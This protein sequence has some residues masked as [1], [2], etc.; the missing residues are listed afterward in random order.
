MNANGTWIMFTIQE[1]L[2]ALPS[3]Q[4]K[5]VLHN[6]SVDKI[7]LVPD[8]ICGVILW[9][10]QTYVALDPSIMMGDAAQ[11]SSVYLLLSHKSQVCIKITRVIA[12][13]SLSENEIRWGCS[14]PGEDFRIGFF[15]MDE[16]QGSIIDE[17]ALVA[18]G[19][20]ILSY[21]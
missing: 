7:P 5:E 13:H 12:I 20:R 18:L 8:S 3:T 14:L 4:V 1:E 15:D 19:E 10:G 11:E 21:V 16:R 17:E 2:F 6:I 9:H